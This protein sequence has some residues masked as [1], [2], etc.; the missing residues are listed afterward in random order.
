MNP[1]LRHFLPLVLAGLTSAFAADVKAPAT[2]TP[3]AATPATRPAM[4]ASRA[5]APAPR[6]EPVSSLAPTAPFDTYRLVGD[7]NI[8]NP[9]R[10]GRYRDEAPQPKTDTISFTGVMQYEKGTF[11]FFDG[12]EAQYRKT[13]KVGGT[14]GPFTLKK[15][16]TASVEVSRDDKTFTLTMGQQFRRPEGGDWSLLGAEQASAE[17]A[18]AAAAAQSP[19][20]VAPVTTAPADASDVVKKLIEAR[21]KQLKQ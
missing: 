11:A 9:N 7:R 5:A 4:P 14:V 15:I 20:N 21:Q 13:L 16:S 10:T 17:A 6:V 3:A 8:F 19:T 2:T 18:A 1:R 12:S